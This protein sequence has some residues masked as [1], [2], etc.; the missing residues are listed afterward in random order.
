MKAKTKTANFLACAWNDCPKSSSYERKY[1]L[2]MFNARVATKKGCGA[3]CT[4]TG[5]IPLPLNTA[6]SWNIKV[7]KTQKKGKGIY[8]GVAPMKI[9]TDADENH[10]KCG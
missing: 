2:V 1:S 9:N 8:I 3:P 4:I 6:T 5:N 7:H 10:K